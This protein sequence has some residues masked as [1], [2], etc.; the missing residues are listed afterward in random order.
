MSSDPTDI[1]SDTSSTPAY[2]SPG[3]A[4]VSS[5][6]ATATPSMSSA[7]I[8]KPHESGDAE[9]PPRYIPL[10]GA[11]KLWIV[12]VSL[13]LASGA[14]IWS[15]NVFVDFG[16]DAKLVDQDIRRITDMVHSVRSDTNHDTFIL[17]H[18][19]NVQLQMK[20]VLTH[21]RL[22][23]LGVGVAIALVALGF[24]LFAIGADGAF[25][26]AASQ[27]AKASLTIQ[28]TAPG[29]LC[30][31]L[32][33]VLAVLPSAI[34]ANLS[35]GAATLPSPIQRFDTPS[36]G[37]PTSSSPSDHAPMRWWDR[38]DEIDPASEHDILDLEGL[39]DG[40]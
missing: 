37:W 2:A 28:G 31:V 12:F 18:G 39:F 35:I 30:F 11:M 25:T 16:D 23:A 33:A 10:T 38:P 6:D 20:R 8:A 14:I 3:A 24:A 4:D 9:L 27:G 5:G 15:I 36:S 22:Q 29:L 1:P 34:P 21:Q 26:V 7:L 17:V 13:I 40:E 32:G 19:L